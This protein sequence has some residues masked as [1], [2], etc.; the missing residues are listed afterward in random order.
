MAKI[1]RD[2]LAAQIYGQKNNIDAWPG[3]SPAN[4][5]P[6]LKQAKDLLPVVNY[7]VEEAH[8]LGFRDGVYDS[9][10][11]TGFTGETVEAIFDKEG[12]VDPGWR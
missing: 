12:L 3:L 11:M 7:F 10:A 9:Q 4:Q 6:Y 5:E 1:T 8:L 2:E